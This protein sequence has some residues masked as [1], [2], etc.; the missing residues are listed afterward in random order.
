MKNGFAIVQ[1]CFNVSDPQFIAGAW[2]IS[3]HRT[4]KAARK[5]YDAAHCRLRRQD[6]A[7]NSWYDWHCLA[8]TD[9]T[10]RLLTPEEHE[11]WN[12]R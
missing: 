8:V 1:S 11:K 6:G 9:G 5:A 2:I 10:L 7:Q 12:L 3:R 4:I